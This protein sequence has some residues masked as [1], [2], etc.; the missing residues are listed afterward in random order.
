MQALFQTLFLLHPFSQPQRTQRRRG[1]RREK[2]LC[3]LCADS[4]ASAVK[5]KGTSMYDYH[6]W[7][8]LPVNAGMGFY[9][10]GNGIKTYFHWTKK[11]YL[12]VG[13]LVKFDLREI[14][15][16]LKDKKV[17]VEELP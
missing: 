8:L 14:E 13:R 7:W 17:K 5:K 15:E 10:I 9:V 4:A 2:K 1:G 3:V 12:K 6:L 11:R 16:W